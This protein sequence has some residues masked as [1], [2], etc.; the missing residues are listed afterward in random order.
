MKIRVGIRDHWTKAD[1]PV[2]QS[3]SGL[4]RVIGLPV[5]VTLDASLLWHELGQSCT[6]PDTFVP[7]IVGVVI[8][9]VDRMTY[10]LEDDDNAVWSEHLLEAC[11]RTLKVRVAVS[12]SPFVCT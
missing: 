9:W 6:D 7:S 4:T 5:D 8:D 2:Q 3:I 1:S 12:Q 11:G 10:M